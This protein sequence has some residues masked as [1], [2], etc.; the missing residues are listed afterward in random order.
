MII[1]QTCIPSFDCHPHVVVT[2]EDLKLQKTLKKSENMLIKFSVGDSKQ[3]QW[4]KLENC[5]SQEQKIFYEDLDRDKMNL[6]ILIDG[7][8]F[9]RAKVPLKEVETTPKTSLTLQNNAGVDVGVAAVVIKLVNQCKPTLKDSL[10]KTIQG[11][12]L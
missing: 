6:E 9:A 11:P 2:I 5:V 12:M 10:I 7:K 1:F 3:R 4:E 8:A